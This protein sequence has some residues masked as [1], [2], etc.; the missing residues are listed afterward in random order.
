[1]SIVRRI[2][3]GVIAVQIVTAAVIIAW[4]FYSVRP[5]I[6][7]LQVQN[8]QET[9]L[10]SV[11]A[12]EKYF[13][14]VE[15]AIQATQHLISTNVLTRD[16]PEQLVRYLHD[17]LRLWPQFAGLYVGFPDG[18]FYYVMR[19]NEESANGTRTKVISYPAGQR[20]VTLTWR[21]PGYSTVRTARDPQDTYDP[22]T[23][24]WYRAALEKDGVVWTEPYIFFTS[25]KPGI[26]AAVAVTDARGE[27]AAVVG[28]D[29]EIGQVSKYLRQIAFGPQRSAFMVGP[30]GEII[31]HSDI[32]TVL[33]DETA[34][35]GKPRFLKIAELGLEQSV[36]DSIASHLSQQ[37][38]ANVPA[39]WQEP[40]RDGRYIV[41][42][43]RMSSA[44]WP[45]HIV[46]IRPELDMIGG[47]RASDLFL[48]A[49]VLSA[50]ALAVAIGYSLALGI[51]RPL[52]VLWANAKLARRGNVE[53]MEDMS[54]GY[55]EIDGTAAI[56]REMAET[57][58]GR[59]T[60]L[61]SEDSRPGQRGR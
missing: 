58:R 55:D 26:T 53:L 57:R 15:T 43:G 31:S 32:D 10:R 23:R 45:W 33:T 38:A 5:E 21:D 14:P 47:A 17:Q 9:V 49:I 16:R 46:M 48:I 51:G 25:R 13:G 27:P 7:A 39:V 11:E 42:V 1:M 59:G 61:P 44:N 56:L 34:G 18:G 8:A 35:N 60:P 52:A 22:R 4:F 29:I 20:E 50:T 30:Q 12:T 40:S 2:F 3:L 54:S 37:S 19:D 41:A 24:P 6:D 28:I 36:R